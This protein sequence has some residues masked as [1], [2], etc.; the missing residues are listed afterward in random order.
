MHERIIHI[1]VCVCG[2]GTTMSVCKIRSPCL[3]FSV[4]ACDRQ[5]YT[6]RQTDRQIDRQTYKKCLPPA[7]LGLE[8]PNVTGKMKLF[9]PS[10]L[11]LDCSEFLK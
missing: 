1:Y 10:S 4:V 9:L 2:V 8:Q 7:N 3:A 11:L 6:D 5:T